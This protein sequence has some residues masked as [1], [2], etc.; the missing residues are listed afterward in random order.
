[1]AYKGYR[2]YSRHTIVYNALVAILVGL[3]VVLLILSYL[4]F[5]Q[6]LN[7]YYAAVMAPIAISTAVIGLILLGNMERQ[8]EEGY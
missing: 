7:F 8:E 5:T 6:P 4:F 1:M 2:T 3:V